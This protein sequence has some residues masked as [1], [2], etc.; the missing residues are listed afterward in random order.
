METTEMETTE[1]RPDR[2]G[3]LLHGVLETFN[4]DQV[5]DWLHNEA[6]YR[7]KGHNALVLTK[8]AT[9]RTVVVCIGKDHRLHEHHAPGPFTLT[10]LRGRIRFVLEPHG[11]NIA[12]EL[13]Q[14]QLLVLEEPRL[15]EVV[16]LEEST[17][18]LT[19]DNFNGRANKISQGEDITVA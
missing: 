14:G 15:H 17:F 12:T 11:E 1:N 9:L 2:T 19:I 3:R 10:M 6:E 13:G 18:L 16:A 5:I 4:L 7:D 8:D